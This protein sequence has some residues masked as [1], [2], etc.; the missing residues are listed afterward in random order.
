MLTF[1]NGPRFLLN[2]MSMADHV[3]KIRVN[4]AGHMQAQRGAIQHQKVDIQHVKRVLHEFK[5][6]PT[7][8]SL[9]CLYDRPTSP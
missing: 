7:P 3:H 4:R 1:Y 9:Y 5:V 8:F 6:D 2:T